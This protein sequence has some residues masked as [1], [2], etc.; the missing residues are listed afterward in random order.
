MSE[1]RGM[2]ERALKLLV[3]IMGLE[4]WE[5]EVKYV[6]RTPKATK[7][8][9]MATCKAWPVHEEATLTFYLDVIA[10]STNGTR[11]EVEDLVAHELVH[12][13][14]WPGRHVEMVTT[15][16]ARSVLRALRR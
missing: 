12:A 4:T 14:L 8:R 13:V 5:L 2:I 6:R 11:R 9:S 1:L 16:V 10:D 15:H 3:P 7:Q